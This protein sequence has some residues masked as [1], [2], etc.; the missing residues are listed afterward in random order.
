MRNDT[1]ICRKPHRFFSSDMTAMVWGLSDIYQMYTLSNI[2]LSV[3]TRRI[4]LAM[5]ASLPV[6]LSKKTMNR[7]LLDEKKLAGVVLAARRPT[8]HVVREM[9]TLRTVKYLAT[10]LIY[11]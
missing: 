9:N 7:Q 4:L 1:Y 8:E 11:A 3:P 6:L 2:H 10:L 5:Q